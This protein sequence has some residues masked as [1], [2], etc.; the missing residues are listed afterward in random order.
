METKDT[1]QGI[2]G[3]KF[4]QAMLNREYETARSLLSDE[5]KLVYPVQKLE[6]KFERMM[7]HTT[8]PVELP[9]PAELPEVE[10][11]D[12]RS[13]G[14][15]SLDSEGWAYIAI[16]SE[17]VTITA[18]PFGQKYLITDLIWGRP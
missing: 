18:I 16:R 14:D 6:Q 15:S 5:L 1:P 13:L 11:L 7:N 17:A 10:V 3:F 2:V 8:A 9:A 4:A 12:N